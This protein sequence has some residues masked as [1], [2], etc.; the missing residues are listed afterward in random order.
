[1]IFFGSLLTH[2]LVFFSNETTQ[3]CFSRRIVMLC[4]WKKNRNWNNTNITFLSGWLLIPFKC[5]RMFT[6]YTFVIKKF[7]Y[8]YDFHTVK[9]LSQLFLYFLQKTKIMPFFQ[10][11]YTTSS[12]VW[13][14]FVDN[15]K[16][17]HYL[18]HNLFTW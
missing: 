16:R 17:K 10:Y 4:R 3:N 11:K 8:F 13:N 2:L 9:L 18:K 12:I 14:S 6:L 7:S 1:M 15:G 5:I